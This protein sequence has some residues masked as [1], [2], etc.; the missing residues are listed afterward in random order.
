MGTYTWPDGDVYTGMWKDDKAYGKL[1]L[2]L[3]NLQGKGKAVFASGNVFEG[4]FEEDERKYGKYTFKSGEVHEAP[5]ALFEYDKF[6]KY[7]DE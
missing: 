1:I 2:V 6:V 3:L 4:E 5:R 7:L